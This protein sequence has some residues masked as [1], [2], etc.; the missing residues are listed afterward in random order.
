M[1][2]GWWPRENCDNLYGLGVVVMA[3]IDTNIGSLHG[4]L[5]F[6]ESGTQRDD[7]K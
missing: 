3:L 5:C 7:G 4:G 1:H 6:I 2:P